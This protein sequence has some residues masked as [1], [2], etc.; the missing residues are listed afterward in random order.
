MVCVEGVGLIECFLYVWGVG[1]VV[2]KLSFGVLTRLFG[3]LLKLFCK[4]GWGSTIT[5]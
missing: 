1:V 4:G 2:L 5:F 3:V